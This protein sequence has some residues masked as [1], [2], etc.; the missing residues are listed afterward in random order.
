MRRGGRQVLTGLTG[1]SFGDSREGNPLARNGGANRK[2]GRSPASLQ[3]ARAQA[4]LSRTS[5]TQIVPEA[6]AAR[7]LVAAAK[8]SLGLGV[9]C[10]LGVTEGRTGTGRPPNGFVLTTLPRGRAT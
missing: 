7:Q 9:A 5:Q 8:L 2:T 4:V 1:S 10:P 6:Q 3:A